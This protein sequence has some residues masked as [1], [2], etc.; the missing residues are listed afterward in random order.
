MVV[1]TGDTSLVPVIAKLPMSGVMD[2]DVAPLTSQFNVAV[3][4]S[5]IDFES[6]PNALITGFV[7][8][9]GLMVTRWYTSDDHNPYPF[10]TL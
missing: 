6:T 3:F 4:P 5:R 1:L 9:G 8:P 10:W 7:L 2:T